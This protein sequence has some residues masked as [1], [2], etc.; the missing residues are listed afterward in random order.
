[1]NP[2]RGSFRYTAF[3]IAALSFYG[4]QV[5]ADAPTLSGVPGAPEIRGQ[6]FAEAWLV[7]RREMDG[8]AAAKVQASECHAWFDEMPTFLLRDTLRLAVDPEVIYQSAIRLSARKT[9]EVRGLLREIRGRYGSQLPGW[10]LDAERI[11]AG[12]AGV[13]S[14]AL[15]Q[16]KSPVFERRRSA[17]ATLTAAGDKEGY[18]YLRSAVKKDDEEGRFAAWALGR[19][20][21]KSDELLLRAETIRRPQDVAL[22]AALGSLLYQRIFPANYLDFLRKYRFLADGMSQY[23]MYESWFIAV[24]KAVENGA[25]DMDTLRI[26]TIKIRKDPG[27]GEDPELS[28]RRLTAFVDFLDEQKA[29]RNGQAFVFQPT[30]FQETLDALRGKGTGGEDRSRSVA[31][32]IAASILL[33]SVLGPKV[34]YPNHA[35]P[36]AGV[37]AVSPNADRVLDGNIGTSWHLRRKTPLVLE[38]PRA[39]FIRSVSLLLF[40]G[41]SATGDETVSIS[42]SGVDIAGR[43]WTKTRA[44]RLNLFQFQEFLISQDSSGRIQLN[45]LETIQRANMC[46]SEIRFDFRDR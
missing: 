41:G 12:D 31:Q 7:Y 18:A 26:E 37:F 20:G 27:F 4:V 16:L 21:D 46:V 8:L 10:L 42:I 6:I 24:Y 33:M 25:R 14:D 15:A 3:F 38:H 9:A 36:T 44:L 35:V 28:D 29:L 32:R 45:V 34:D 23:G 22:A 5:S 1:M 43:S 17:G 11:R 30:N 19:F 13:R 39:Q 2:L 40:C